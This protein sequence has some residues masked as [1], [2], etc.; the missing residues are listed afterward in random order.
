MLTLSEPIIH[1]SHADPP[2]I[3]VGS[4]SEDAPLPRQPT[5]RF[6]NNRRKQLPE[7]S[8]VQERKVA[9][10]RSARHHV[11]SARSTEALSSMVTI[12][13][14]SRAALVSL[15]AL[16][17]LAFAMIELNSHHVLAA[18]T[19]AFGSLALGLLAIDGAGS[20]RAPWL[21]VTTLIASMLF[22][23]FVGTRVWRSI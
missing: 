10:I 21:R 2:G 20:S 1:A 5:A 22:I 7:K 19:H 16:A 14:S 11:T 15:A 23:G 13:D 3:A 17:S 6:K 12:S 4:C 8:L 9:W 18:A